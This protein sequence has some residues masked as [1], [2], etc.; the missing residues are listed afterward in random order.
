MRVVKTA[1]RASHVDRYHCVQMTFRR[2]RLSMGALGGGSRWGLSAGALGGRQRLRGIIR[3][4]PSRTG[5]VFVAVYL[6]SGKTPKPTQASCVNLR[7]GSLDGPLNRSLRNGGPWTLKR[8]CTRARTSRLLCVGGCFL[9]P[10]CLLSLSRGGPFSAEIHFK[11]S[12]MEDTDYIKVQPKR[13]A[14]RANR[15][16][17]DGR[18]WRNLRFLEFERQYVCPFPRI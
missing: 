14:P 10:S 3:V 17:A 8:H 15:E 5:H 18:F 13:F 9:S 2:I 6:T 1:G 4:D 12:T 16:T 7:N 11:Q